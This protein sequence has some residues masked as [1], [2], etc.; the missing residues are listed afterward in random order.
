MS[1]PDFQLQRAELRGEEHVL[2]LAVPPDLVFF[3]GHFE[4]NPMLPGVAQ[5][6]ALVDARARATFATALAG[7]G[8]RRMTRLKFQATVLPGEGIELGLTLVPGAEPQV[9]FRIERLR[10]DGARET[11]T[12]GALTYS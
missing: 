3:E 12:T 1:S 9:R 10:A 4:N 8:A 5:L 2:T 11:A 6:L 7:R